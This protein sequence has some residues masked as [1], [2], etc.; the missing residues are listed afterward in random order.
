MLARLCLNSLLAKPLVE[1]D[2]G[3]GA[4]QTTPTDKQELK[5]ED[6]IVFMSQVELLNHLQRHH[7][8]EMASER[9]EVRLH[10]SIVFFCLLCI[11]VVPIG[12]LGQTYMVP[13]T[14]ISTSR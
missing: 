7:P 3:D 6:D 14:R 8:A 13:S 5:H 9:L 10:H 4:P 1:P 11:L 2:A 12:I